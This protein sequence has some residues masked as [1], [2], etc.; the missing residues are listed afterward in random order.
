[1]LITE[2]EAAALYCATLC[3]EVDLKIG[4]RFLIC[5]AGGGTVV[6]TPG[7]LNPLSAPSSL[8]SSPVCSSLSAF[9]CAA[10]SAGHRRLYCYIP[11]LLVFFFS[12]L[13]SSR[14]LFVVHVL[15]G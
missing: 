8:F 5:D 13:F 10:S 14:S 15:V 2:P 11:S 3:K 9:S 12:S 7:S 6:F 4:N 1:M